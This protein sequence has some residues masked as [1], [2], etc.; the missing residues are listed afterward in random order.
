MHSF[1]ILL[2]MIFVVLI[3]TRKVNAGEDK[4]IKDN[5]YNGKSLEVIK[6]NTKARLLSQIENNELDQAEDN[7]K[8]LRILDDKEEELVI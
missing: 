2:L 8:K 1:I 6:F 5:I 3:S 7:L 4:L